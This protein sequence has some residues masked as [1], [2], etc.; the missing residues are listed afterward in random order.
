M[1]S[2]FQMS[3]RLTATFLAIGHTIAPGLTDLADMFPLANGL[4]ANIP[5]CW[6]CR[7]SF[8]GVFRVH[9][10]PDEPVRSRSID[11]VRW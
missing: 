6:S 11:H 2:T 10:S 8:D 3:L 4:R 7:S 1:A 5:G 9:I